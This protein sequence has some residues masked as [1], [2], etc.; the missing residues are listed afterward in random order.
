[1]ILRDIYSLSYVVNF[2]KYFRD[3]LKVFLQDV[4]HLSSCHKYLEIL[5]ARR[6]VII[7][8]T[9]FLKKILIV[10]QGL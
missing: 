8:V 7:Q 2:S 6:E 1:M 5:S 3:I 9:A 10:F 4:C